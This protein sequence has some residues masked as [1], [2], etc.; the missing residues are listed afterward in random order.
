MTHKLRWRESSILAALC[1]PLICE[2]MILEITSVSYKI[3]S[4]PNLKLSL[5]L[6]AKLRGEFRHYP[7]REYVKAS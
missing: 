5:R 7:G 3:T 1:S 4:F 6:L 2:V